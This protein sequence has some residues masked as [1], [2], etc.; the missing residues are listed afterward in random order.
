MRLF[1]ETR[2]ALE[3]QTATAEI[4][5]VI[6]DSPEDVQPVLD[7]IVHSAA[8][9]FE[10]C[11]A[12]IT[13]LQDGWLHW[14][15]GAGGT[16]EWMQRVK[17]IY[18]IPLDPERAP[19][20]RAIAECRTIEILDAHAPDTPFFTRQSARAGRFGSGVFV[21]L[22]REGQGIGTIILT[23]PQVGYKLSDKQLELV[24]TF[25]AQAVI[26]IENVRLF[27]ETQEALDRQTATAEV[28]QV[29]G[30]SVADSAPVFDKIIDSCRRLFSSEQLGIFTLADDR[31][32]HA[33]A[34]RGDAI[35]AIA[36]TFPKP[37]DQTISGRVMTERRTVHLPDAAAASDVPA[38][39]HEMR[40][41]M[42]NFSAV[43]VPLIW[44]AAASERSASS[45]SR[46]APSP[47]TKWG[48][49]GPSPTRR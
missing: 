9:L 11:D 36:K 21:P 10:P 31:R 34:W 2:E 37:V 12:T 39:V 44:R 5:A 4:L 1:N 22:I 16:S 3:R 32:M 42:G 29:I 43:W 26:A 20:A 7:A 23:H 45:G 17:A 15:G 33:V 41:H 40:A 46:C 28:L 35:D 18:P 47:T 27:K 24:Q 49:S 48:S 14:R 8:E 19:S 13:M 38:S 30:S 25:A 6:A